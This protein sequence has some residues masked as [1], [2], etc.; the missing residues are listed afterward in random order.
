MLNRPAWFI[1]SVLCFGF[2]CPA[3]AQD[4]AESAI[5]LGGSAHSQ[6]RAQ[7]SLGA[8]VANSLGGASNVIA[9]T[10]ARSAAHENVTSNSRPDQRRA[11][12]LTAVPP[13]GDPLKG[14]AAPTYKLSN[15]SSIRVS[16]GLRPAAQ[17]TCVRYCGSQP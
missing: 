9:S 11:Q 2:S 17:T 7:R 10:N 14:I 13:T 6:V 5:I 15:G 1:C 12:A 3:T 4:A 8:A 16:G